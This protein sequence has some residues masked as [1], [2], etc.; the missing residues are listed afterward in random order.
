VSI[1]SFLTFYENEIHTYENDD[2]EMRVTSGLRLS[3]YM[4]LK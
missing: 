1:E 2:V 4:T 3:L